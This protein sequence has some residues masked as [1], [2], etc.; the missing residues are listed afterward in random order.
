MVCSTLQARL[1]LLPGPI[2]F[3]APCQEVHQHT[4]QQHC[5]ALFSQTTETKPLLQFKPK[6]NKTEH[7]REPREISFLMLITQLKY[8][9]KYLLAVLHTNSQVLTVGYL[10][11]YFILTG[12]LTKDIA[13]CR[14]PTEQLT[15]ARSFAW[16]L[17][18]VSISKWKGVCIYIT[19]YICIFL[20]LFSKV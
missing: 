18:Q 13:L 19:K 9:L 3:P 6:K 10:C 15:H 5:T 7:R 11:N 8:L 2:S 16:R 4:A 1:G 20:F 14:L 12:L 17:F